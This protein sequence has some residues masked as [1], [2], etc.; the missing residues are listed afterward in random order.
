MDDRG[1]ADAAQL[2]L[3][4]AALLDRASRMV[5]ALALELVDALAKREDLGP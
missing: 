1:I 3:E 4:L 2:M 5:G